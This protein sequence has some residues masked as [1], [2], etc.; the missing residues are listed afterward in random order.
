M[1][2][3]PQLLDIEVKGTAY[4]AE[5]RHVPSLAGEGLVIGTFVKSA[6]FLAKTSEF[7]QKMTVAGLITLPV[8]L[9]IG[10][11]FGHLVG[12][13][14]VDAAGALTALAKGDNAR[15]TKHE[16]SGTEIG[17][18]ARAFADLRSEVLNSFKL[19][20]ALADLPIGVMT[21]DGSND[22]RIDYLNPAL[23]GL[24]STGG[25]KTDIA[26]PRHRN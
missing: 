21:I 26:A 24:L 1:T 14:L 10:F 12:R 6:P 23:A 22:W 5:F 9:V 19:R 20:Q 2:G 16:K 3:T 18:M 11:I 8:A 13:P 17:D 15:L 4:R 7:I 25:M